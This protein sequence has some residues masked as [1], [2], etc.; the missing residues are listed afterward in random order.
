V[1]I[2]GR[3]GMPAIPVVWCSGGTVP[4]MAGG[5]GMVVVHV[6]PRESA[7]VLV[8]IVIVAIV[9]VVVCVIRTGIATALVGGDRL[10]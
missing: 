8:V 4:S 5:G 1:A 6:M 7:A 9:I 2:E 10:C 3:S